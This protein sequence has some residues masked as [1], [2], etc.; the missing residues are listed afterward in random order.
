MDKVVERGFINE[1]STIL[2][3]TTGFDDIVGQYIHEEVFFSKDALEIPFDEGTGSVEEF[4]TSTL[5]VFKSRVLE[6]AT[7]VVPS[8]V[9]KD[10]NYNVINSY[11]AVVDENPQLEDNLDDFIDGFDSENYDIEEEIYFEEEYDDEYGDEYLEDEIYYDEVP[12]EE[13]EIDA[14]IEKRYMWRMML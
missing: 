10:Y 8:F 5:K 1:R 13:S 4:K 3:V 11:H 2:E 14:P 6:K 9:E 7:E 12:V